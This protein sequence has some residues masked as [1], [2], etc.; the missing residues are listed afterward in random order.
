MRNLNKDDSRK[1]LFLDI[2]GVLN[3]RS[4]FDNSFQYKFDRFVSEFFRIFKKTR[5]RQY[6]LKLLNRLKKIHDETHCTIVMSSS[7]RGIYFNNE[8]APHVESLKRDLYKRGIRIT[9]RTS[10]NYDKEEYLK[11][12]G[13]TFLKD[14]NGSYNTKP[15]E[16][17]RKEI[18]DRFY[19]RG[20]QIYEF[21]RNWKKEH[22]NV[23]F[24][25]LDDDEGDLSLFNKDGYTRFVQ[26]TWYDTK[27]KKGGIQKSH[28]EKTISILNDPNP[29][30]ID[31]MESLF[32]IE[33]NQE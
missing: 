2:D 28:V 9:H 16:I 1:L 20:Y 26:T 31:W 6:S 10:N 12:N 32:Y 5:T 27:T 19:E 3:S 14:E 33:K 17:P 30:V 4:F 21:I 18:V 15:V 22:P 8:F 29:P 24:A 13:V 7:W 23:V 11:Q 25:V